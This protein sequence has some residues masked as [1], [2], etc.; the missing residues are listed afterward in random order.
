MSKIKNQFAAA[1]A[2]IFANHKNLDE[3]YVTSDGQ[4][5]TEK[6][7]A[8]DHSRYLKDND[9]KH[10]ER[11][12]ADTYTEPEEIDSLDVNIDTEPGTTDTQT[13][14][15]TKEELK[16][17]VPLTGDGI[18]PAAAEKN[19]LISQYKELYGVAPVHN[20][21]LE[22]LKAKIEE[23]ESAGKSADTENKEPEAETTEQKEAAEDKGAA[24]QP[25][26]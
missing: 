12:F 5:F 10:F 18:E 13:T 17:E 7:K 14:E 20:I 4:G 1:A 22:K 21:S 8:V 24:E 23:K 11:G 3:I 26:A 15:Q 19:T 25:E 16:Q 9:V 2:L 6:N